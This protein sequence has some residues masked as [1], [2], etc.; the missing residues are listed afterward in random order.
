MYVCVFI[1]L[2]MY[3]CIY[4]C[5]CVHSMYMC[6]RSMYVCMYVYMHER[7]RPFAIKTCSYRSFSGVKFYYKHSTC[8]VLIGYPYNVLVS[9]RLI[10]SS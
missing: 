6:V 4:V 8:S 1:V 3:V 5:M 2:C 10:V 9:D 7:R